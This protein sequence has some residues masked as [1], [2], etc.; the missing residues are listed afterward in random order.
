[1]VTTGASNVPAR[2]GRPTFERPAAP[3]RAPNAAPMVLSLLLCAVAAIAEMLYVLGISAGR[4]LG[5]IIAM[6]SFILGLAGLIRE[7]EAKTARP[8]RFVAVIGCLISLYLVLAV[9]YTMVAPAVLK[10]GSAG[11]AGS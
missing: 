11:G 10:W 6:A 5:M 4:P 9:F 2:P 3:P 7:R 1:M 8:V